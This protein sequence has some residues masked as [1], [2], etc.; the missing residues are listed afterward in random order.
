LGPVDW[1]YPAATTATTNVRATAQRMELK[2]IGA[3][4]KSLIKSVHI[5]FGHVEPDKL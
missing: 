4:G 2:F 3:S 1:E 5:L